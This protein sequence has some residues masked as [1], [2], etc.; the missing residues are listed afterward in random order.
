[1]NTRLAK[2]SN[3][4][5]Q[6]CLLL[7]KFFFFNVLIVT[8]DIITDIDTAISHYQNNDVNWCLFTSL[9]IFAPF[10]YVMILFTSSKMLSF[11]KTYR[12]D[13]QY[14]S[15]SEILWQFP[16]FHPLKWVFRLNRFNNFL[17]SFNLSQRY[18]VV[19][20]LLQ[21]FLKKFSEFQ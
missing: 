7:L 15:L 4:L 8:A 1:M 10:G 5:F 19:K 18:V 13:G 14:D 16:L 20:Y 12:M 9:V 17:N 11:T 6:H 3:P 2:R 21:H